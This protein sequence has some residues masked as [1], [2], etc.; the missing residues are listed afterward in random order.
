MNI[1]I[2]NI[3]DAEQIRE[4]YMPYVLNTAIS[5][6]YEVPSNEE[7]QNRINN[8]LKEYPYLVAEKDDMIVGYAYAGSFR[9]REAYKYSAEL[10]V[11]IRQDMRGKGIGRSLYSELEKW[12]IKQNVYMV[13]AC[14][15]STDRQDEY[16]TDDSE[17]FHK[18]MGFEMAG[19][20]YLCGYKFGKWYSIIWMDKIIKEKSTVPSAFIP[21]SKISKE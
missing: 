18:K 17:K 14:I 6:E 10:S 12:L 4:I 13:H 16:L 19:K 20:H 11:Y 7:F 1:R 8:T 5:F 15:A 3:D 21:F 9:S 2:A